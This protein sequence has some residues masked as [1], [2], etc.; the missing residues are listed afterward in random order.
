MYVVLSYV[1]IAS[2]QGGSDCPAVLVEQVPKALHH[3]RVLASVRSDVD[4]G[5]YFFSGEFTYLLAGRPR[6]QRG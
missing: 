3:G 2:G 1:R 6:T 4:A 5:N